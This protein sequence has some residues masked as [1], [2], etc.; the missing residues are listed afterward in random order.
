[1]YYFS[2]SD[3]LDTFF[4]FF[5]FVLEPGRPDTLRYYVDFLNTSRK[6]LVSTLK[7]VAIAYIHVLPQFI[8]ILQLAT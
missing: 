2:V 6:I 4:F 1:M 7:Q 3:R 5:F 8:T